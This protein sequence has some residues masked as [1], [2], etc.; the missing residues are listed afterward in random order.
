MNEL[1]R[2]CILLDIDSGLV[3]KHE[4]RGADYVILADYGIGGIK[5]YSV[6][7]LDLQ[8]NEPEPKSGP[9]GLNDLTVSEL[10]EMADSLGLELPYRALKADLIA[11]VEGADEEE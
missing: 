2:A 6:P 9:H 11:A 3:V 4:H 1:E 8:Y 7:I 10:R 5:K